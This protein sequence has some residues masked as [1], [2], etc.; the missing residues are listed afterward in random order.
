MVAGSA[1]RW[2]GRGFLERHPERGSALL[3]DL[4]ATDDTGYVQVCAAL[5]EFDL[6]D[7]LPEISAPVL[8]VAGS[9]DT[10]TPTDSLR[11]LAEH[12]Q[13]GR[14]VELEGVA[15]LA[16]AEAPEVVARLVR[17]HL[18]GEV[19]PPDENATRTVSE[20]REV[21]LAVRREVLGDAHVDRARPPPPTSPGTSRS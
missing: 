9:R 12:V 10:A 3:E 14:L 17:E 18:L 19:Q 5:A 1:E 6:R 20:V 15:H 2:F 11:Q 16:P 4:R 21:G 7:R 13:D 8:A